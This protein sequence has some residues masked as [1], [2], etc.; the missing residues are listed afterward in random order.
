[1][2][3]MVPIVVIKAGIFSRAISTPLT[4]PVI[5]PTLRPM[6][7]ATGILRFISLIALAVMI[8]P[9]AIT[10][11]TERSMP[12]VTITSV[13]PIASRETTDTC[14]VIFSIFSPLKKIGLE[15]AKMTTRASSAT[16][17]PNSRKLVIFLNTFVF[18]FIAFHLP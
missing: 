17:T 12:P 18:S 7:M 1:M 3:V 15:N 14:R 10:A 8:P 5:I 4:I 9:A 2:M 6:I 13:I 11:L 16:R